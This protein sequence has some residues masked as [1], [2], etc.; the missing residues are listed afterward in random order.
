MNSSTSNKNS[1]I[2][3]N[4]QIVLREE[5]DDWALLFDPETGNVCGLNPVGVFIWKLIDGSRT[6]NDIYKAVSDEC[7]D[8][9]DSAQEEVSSFIQEICEKG[10]AK[11]C[12]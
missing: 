12:N 7:P 5:F 9:P 10:Y 4:D 6:V 3:K 8:A 11:A 1:T 2:L